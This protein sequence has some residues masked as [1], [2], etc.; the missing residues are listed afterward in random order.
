MASSYG[1]ADIEVL[2][3]LEPVRKRPGMYIAGTDTPAGLHQ[4]VFEILDNSVDEAMNGHASQISITLHEDHE[5]VTVND[6]GRGI[7][8]EKH[9]KFNLSTLELILTTLHAGGKFSDKNY[10][11]AG[12]LHGVGSSVVN[13]LSEE[14]V[15]TVRRDGKEYVQ[16]FSRGKP[17]SS[18]KSQKSTSPVTG[19][20]I[21]F[22]P[23]SEIFA[24]TEFSPEIL[25]SAI[26]TKA[27]LNPGLKLTF[28]DERSG[29][30]EDFQYKEG[31]I[32]Y[33]K[34]L[35][36]EKKSQIVGEEC[37]AFEREDDIHV[38]LALCWTS[39]TQETFYSYVNGIHTPDGG[40]HEVGARNGIVRALRN[41]F[42]VHD[43]QTKG[44]KI[45]A[46]DIREGLTC[47]VAVKLPGGTLQPQFQGQT[48][49]RLNNPEVAPMVENVA[50]L[51]EQALNAKPSVATAITNRIIMA[52][53]ARAASREAG[54]NVRRKI[55]I[56]HRLTLPG[57][58]ADCSSTKPAESELFI[59]EGDSAGGSAKQA[60]DRHYQAVLPLRGKV[61][62]TVAASSKKVLENAE[63]SNIVSAL[64]CGVGDSMRL[65]KLRYGKVII[66]TD[67][68]ADGM[69]IATLLM[70]FFFQFMRPLVEAG[71][72][73]LGKPPLYG[74]F[75]RGAEQKG[76]TLK[77]A[78]KKRSVAKSG[79]KS[80]RGRKKSDGNVQWA[81]SDEE[82]QKLMLTSSTGSPKITRFKGLGEMNP[83]TLWETT[84]DPETRTLLR[85]R[86]EDAEAVAS[87]LKELI[88]SDSSLRLRLIQERASQIDLDV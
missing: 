48:K 47:L 69:H 50:K 29:K 36:E 45:G 6:N 1:A 39:G 14:L 41:Y 2:E 78:A 74:I 86:A 9:P 21:F 22:R 87:E 81:Y 72:V 68:D 24:T 64:G 23:D 53:K 77:E 40:S 17:T 85:I 49:S 57:K 30:R 73:Y 27:Y 51:L 61:L 26:K 56:S 37:F 4:L 88:G 60:R 83:A 10:R 52:S 20:K 34:E 5:S 65:D 7:P 84:L 15:A 80:S 82:L 13:A 35:L 16:T 63:L 32:A 62:N 66:L 28:T 58:L 75:A 70:A 54:E 33:L 55:G 76:S 18:V 25:R 67:A 3:G 71:N 59:V 44:A 43:V 79:S 42:A 46:E 31:L 12:G 19:T 8:V 38:S 11:T